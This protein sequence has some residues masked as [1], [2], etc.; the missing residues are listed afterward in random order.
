MVV[1]LKNATID[2]LET[3]ETRR[4]LLMKIVSK[5][6]GAVL[7]LELPEVLCGPFKEKDKIDVR[8]DAKEITKGDQ[9]KLYVEGTVFKVTNEKNFD[10]IAAVGGLKFNL[11]LSD[12]KP[13]QKK[14][15][16]SDRFYLTLD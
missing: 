15:F 2:S 16:S 11:S 13:S 1:R 12:P 7:E 3:T 6:D 8:I 5:S 10:V 14:I 9:A 4:L